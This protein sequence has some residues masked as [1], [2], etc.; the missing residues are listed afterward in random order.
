MGECQLKGRSHR[1]RI[2]MGRDK[3]PRHGRPA[4]SSAGGKLWILKADGDVFSVNA[5]GSDND[6]FP[7]QSNQ[8]DLTNG[9]T[10]TSWLGSLWYRAGP[11][12]YKM[13]P[14]PVLSP[15][16]PERYLDNGSEVQGPVQAFCGWGAHLA[17]C[18]IYNSV[19]AETTTG[20]PTSYL[21]TYGNWE[22]QLTTQPSGPSLAFVDQYDGALAHW[23]GRQMTALSVTSAFAD[24][25]LYCGFADGGVLLLVGLE[26]V[27]E[28]RRHETRR[29]VGELGRRVPQRSVAS[30]GADFHGHENRRHETRR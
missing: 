24:E 25:R 7:S 18:G 8:V 3:R 28:N 1:E 30:R 20:Q 17:F 13:D 19:G 12:F 2:R 10:A 22:P 26:H 9:R 6:W 15:I 11:T 5:D 14:T 27:R 23:P 21:L 16:G 29:T 4:K